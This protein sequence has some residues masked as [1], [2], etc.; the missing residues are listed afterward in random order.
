MY[1][2]SRKTRIAGVHVSLRNFA[3]RDGGSRD[4]I[5]TTNNMLGDCYAAA[6]VEQLSKKELMALD[7]AAYQSETVLPTTIANGCISANRVPD[8]DT[9]VVE[10]QDD[11][12]IAGVAK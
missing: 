6:V 9:I 7:A 12:R 8:P 11:T 2:T 4:R 10:M 1:E 3:T 5:R